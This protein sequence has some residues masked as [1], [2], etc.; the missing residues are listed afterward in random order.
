MVGG[1]REIAAWKAVHEKVTTRYVY[2]I[3]PLGDEFIIR[4]YNIK[5][6]GEECDQ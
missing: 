4:K 6:Y 2:T 3:F 5:I 1:E